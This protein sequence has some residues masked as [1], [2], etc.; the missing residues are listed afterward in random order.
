MTTRLN[1]A[2]DSSHNQTE[3][4][5]RVDEADKS[6]AMADIINIL[7]A[8]ESGSDAASVNISIGVGDGAAASGAFTIASSGAQSVTINGKALTGGTNYIIANLSVTDIASNIVAAV[9]AS[10]DSRLMAVQ[11]A[12]AAGVVTVTA[13]QAGALGNMF[14]TTATGAA[15]AGAATLADGSDASQNVLNF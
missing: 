15:S 10:V 8:L 1:I 7:R 12:S 6:N 14:T 3:L 11:A 13:R 9:N 5:N 4:Q 2:I